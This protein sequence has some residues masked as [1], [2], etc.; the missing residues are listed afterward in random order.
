[1]E[2]MTVNENGGMRVNSNPHSPV[3]KGLATFF[4]YL[5]HPLFM[6]AW[7][8][9]YL[10]Y[11]NSLVFTGETSFEK[12]IVFLRVFSTSIF[13]PLVTVLLLKG[14]GFIKS[15]QL[16]TQKDRI[17]PYV[18]S[19]TFFFWSF[20]VSK[21]LVDPLEMRAFLLSLFITSSVSLLINNYMKVSMHAIAA[22][23]LVSFFTL[24]LFSN[25][26]DDMLSLLL[27][28]LIAGITCSSRFIVSDHKP[29]EIYVGF[30]TGAFLQVIAW[31]IV[32]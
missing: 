19:I 1:M 12:M 23:A 16:R 15:I 24:L 18:A 5:F 21:Q 28:F 29:A 31:M 22:G 11:R 8:C 6:I 7:V 30:F 13:L 3:V 9:L 10:L 25:R 2:Q 26:L 4:S 27:A 17:I 14:L 20:Y 32:K